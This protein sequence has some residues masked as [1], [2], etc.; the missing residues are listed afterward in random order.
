MLSVI[1]VFFKLLLSLITVKA[2]LF[3]SYFNYNC[4]ILAEY[5]CE[6]A[7]IA[8]DASLPSQ[9]GVYLRKNSPFIALFK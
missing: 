7:R 6:V 8:V 1:T 5:P 4:Y 9:T 2:V 3:S